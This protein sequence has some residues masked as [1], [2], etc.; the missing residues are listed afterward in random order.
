MHEA[1][2]RPIRHNPHDLHSVRRVASCAG[3]HAGRNERQRF[4]AAVAVGLASEDAAVEAGVSQA[5]GTR[6][7]RKAGGMPPAMFGPSAKPLSEAVLAHQPGDP[8]TADREAAIAQFPRHPRTAIGA[9]RQGKGRPD[10]RQQYHVVALAAA[11]QPTA[12]GEIAALADPLAATM[13]LRAMIDFSLT[14]NRSTRYKHAARHLLDCA[15]LSSV[16][17]DFGGLEPHDAYEA[18]LRREHGRKSSF[19]SLIA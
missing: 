7:F 1:R 10:M 11:G 17:E 6:W 13:V 15:G 3:G 9:A 14:N 12:P 16:I 8:A 5:V 19:W 18:R 2:Q 4:W